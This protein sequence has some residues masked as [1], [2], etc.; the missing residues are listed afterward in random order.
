MLYCFE[1][2]LSLIVAILP[3]LYSFKNLTL[4][5]PAAVKSHYSSTASGRST[6]SPPRSTLGFGLAGAFIGLVHAATIAVSPDVHLFY[7]IWK[8]LFPWNHPK[9][10]TLKIFLPFPHRLLGHRIRFHFFFFYLLK[11]FISLLLKNTFFLAFEYI[12]LC[13]FKYILISISH[14]C[15]IIQ[16]LFI[17]YW[18]QKRGDL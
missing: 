6:Y 11:L 15:L 2:G 5:P 7:Y 10:P 16:Y 18:G 8:K 12:F 1:V 17:S 14:I 4:L 9:P 3:W 13:M